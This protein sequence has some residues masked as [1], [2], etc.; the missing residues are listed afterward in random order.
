M[1]THMKV[2]DLIFFNL[3]TNEITGFLYLCSKDIF[4]TLYLNALKGVKIKIPNFNPLIRYKLNRAFNYFFKGL[5]FKYDRVAST[6]NIF[7]S[8]ENIFEFLFTCG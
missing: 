8:A 6:G 1:L 2:K 5:T 7:H 3:D 4:D